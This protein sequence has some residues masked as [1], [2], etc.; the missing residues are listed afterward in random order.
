MS[1]TPKG[2]ICKILFFC[3]ENSL[4]FICLRRIFDAMIMSFLNQMGVPLT[5]AVY[6]LFLFEE[7]KKQKQ[8]IKQNSCNTR[9]CGSFESEMRYTNRVLFYVDNLI[10]VNLIILNTVTDLLFQYV[11]DTVCVGGGE[12]REPSERDKM[13]ESDQYGTFFLLACHSIDICNG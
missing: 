5:L 4:L 8:K 3:F 11:H 13:K 7:N 2:V 10:V 12:D 9:Q 1:D 6:V